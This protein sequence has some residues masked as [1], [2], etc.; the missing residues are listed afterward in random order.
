MLD[1]FIVTFK[2]INCGFQ[3]LSHFSLKSIYSTL[4]IA[5]DH[6]LTKNTYM[7]VQTILKPSRKFPVVLSPLQSSTC[8]S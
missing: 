7:Y 8:I 2:L 3:F 1:Y 6:T 5:V 4:M